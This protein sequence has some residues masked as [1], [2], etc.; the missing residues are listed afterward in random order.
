MIDAFKSN[1]KEI[2]VETVKTY[3]DTQP[4][5]I[6]HSPKTFNTLEYFEEVEKRKYFVEPH[7]LKFANFPS[8]DDKSVLEI[9]CGI[10]T[11]ALNFVRSGARYVGIELSPKSL[12]I[13]KSRLRLY[14][15]DANL[16]ISNIEELD[17]SLLRQRFDLIYSFGVLHHTPNLGKALENI[18]KISDEN[19]LFKLMV[20]A[21]DSW[22]QKMIDS[23]FDQPESQKG[24]PIA[25]SYTKEEIAM[26]LEQSGFKIMDIKQDHIFP[27]KVSEYKKYEYKKEPWFEVMPEEIF[28]SLEKSLGWHL[29]IDAKIN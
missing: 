13:A 27:Y 15:F 7:I 28:R 26:I 5:N 6:K 10:G 25:N 2:S 11:D 19:T 3:W 16:F 18:R 1:E 14:G 23:G 17:R 4:C 20:Y 22:K 29:L 9:G 24:C 12:E 21:K 8:W